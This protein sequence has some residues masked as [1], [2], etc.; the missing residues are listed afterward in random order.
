MNKQS[1]PNAQRDLAIYRAFRSGTSKTA[2]AKEYKITRQRVAD[3]C[4]AQSWVEN[5]TE[6]L[7]HIEWREIPS[8]V[9]LD[10]RGFTIVPPKWTQTN[11]T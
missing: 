10:R 4:D 1:N 2:L 6:L 3:I 8:I 9:L 11:K 7:P 5:N